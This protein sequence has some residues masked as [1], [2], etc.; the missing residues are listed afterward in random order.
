M[1]DDAS[2]FRRLGTGVPGLDQILRGGL[3]SH[4]IYSVEGPAGAGK[5]ILANQM[6]HHRAARGEQVVY[7]TLLAESHAHMI[8]HLRG[9]AFFRADLVARNVHYLSGLKVL[10]RDGLSGLLRLL[11]DALTQ[12]QVTLLVI[13]GIAPALGATSAEPAYK[14]FLEELASLAALT[15]CSVVLLVNCEP[16]GS[17][18]PEDT[19]VDGVLRLTDELDRLRPRRHIVV[20]KFR[21][22]GTVRGKHSLEIDDGG[23][24][25]L[26]RLEAQSLRL[27]ERSRLPP[28]RRRVPL[29]V[30]ELDRAL[31]GGLPACST[32]MLLGPSGSGK[33]LLGLQFLAA[34]ASRRENG[35]FFGFFERPHTLLE[36]SQSC[37]LALEDAERR[38]IIRLAWEPFGEGDIDVLGER[39][40]RLVREHQP[41]RLFI[42]GM[43]GLRQSVGDPERLRAVLSAIVD[44]LEAQHITTVYTLETTELYG[45]TVRPPIHGLSAL[46]QN[47]LLLRHSQR[48]GAFQKTL[49]VLKLRDGG[50]D[51]RQR[52]LWITD[53]GIVVEQLATVVPAGIASA[54]SAG[55]LS[56]AGDSSAGHSPPVRDPGW[57][58]FPTQ[59][60]ELGGRPAPRQGPHVLIVD[61]EFGLAELVAEILEDKGYRTAIA[62]NGELALARMGERRPDLVL[63]DLMMPVL[64]GLETLRRMQADPALA[65]VPVVFM[66]ALPEAL[67]PRGAPGH[68]EVLQKP[69]TPDQLFAV[70]QAH[71][72]PP[73]WLPSPSPLNE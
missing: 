42:D 10:E 50:F 33:T 16:S 22:A 26:P 55:A 36:K 25:V 69:F 73:G 43:D 53:A 49:S 57:S 32:T 60:L 71:A 47:I 23:V 40:L 63:L 28:A 66:T 51:P 3:L 61:D 62:I 1:S 39:L 7:L 29:G 19:M 21:G 8:G 44:A 12:R 31:L 65:S 54:P 11:R 2:A 18:R 35:L 15:G 4:S 5:T 9:L 14:L 45:E 38:G 34:G 68:A 64:D 56:A 17:V 20:S 27:P 13:D 72:R 41:Q 52:D 37:G 67:P 24:T 46:T 58:A 6:C 30:P 70:V 59:G 48:A